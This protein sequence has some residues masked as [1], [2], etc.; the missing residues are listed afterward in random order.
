MYERMVDHWC[1]INPSMLADAREFCGR[2]VSGEAFRID[3]TFFFPRSSVLTK[4]NTV[5][6]NDTSNRLKALHDK[7]SEAL[8]I[9]DSLFF[10]G[11]FEKK[12]LNSDHPGL[13][14]VTISIID[15]DGF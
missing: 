6:K 2:L 1:A 13:V 7:I 4:K 3:C 10:D 9:D 11:S 5:K 15:I 14:D 8:G 12:I